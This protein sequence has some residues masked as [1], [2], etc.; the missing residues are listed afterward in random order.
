MAINIPVI[1]K[2]FPFLDVSGDDKPRKDKIKNIPEI[3]YKEATI[4][5]DN[6]YFF[7]PFLYIASILIVT[8]KPPKIFI[9]AKKTAIAPTYNANWLESEFETATAI[10]APTIM[11]DEIALVTDING[12]CKAGV[13]LQTT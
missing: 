10:R 13:T 3:K 12:V 2:I 5:T 6:I 8:R 1:P 9:A 11:T 7:F 4:F